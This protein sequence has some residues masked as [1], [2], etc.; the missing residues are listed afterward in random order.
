VYRAASSAKLPAELVPAAAFG[1]AQADLDQ[2]GAGSA[3]SAFAAHFPD[4]PANRGAGVFTDRLLRLAL[5]DSVNYDRDVKPWLG[6][7]VA[8]AGW[9]DDG[10]LQWEAL[11]ATTDASTARSDLTRLLHGQGLV[12]T[13]G[14]A[15]IAA[16]QKAAEDAV[17]AARVKSL[18]TSSLYQHDISALPGSDVA[19]A[20]FDGAEA[21]PALP[22]PARMMLSMVPAAAELLSTH[23]ALGLRFS[24]TSAELD[25]RGVDTKAPGAVSTS[26]LTG[27]PDGTVG[28]IEL[29]QPDRIL[30]AMGG[31]LALLPLEAFGQTTVSGLA[32]YGHITINS[33]PGASSTCTETV[34]GVTQPCGTV[35]PAHP[36]PPPPS[37]FRLI[38]RF[39]GLRFPADFAALL[40]DRS[41]IAFGGIGL[42]GPKVAVRSHPADLA[43]ALTLA[44]RLAGALTHH[45]GLGLS[46]TTTGGDLVIATGSGYARQ[47]VSGGSLG[48]QPGFR[49]AMGTLPAAVNDAG[50]LD[51]ARIAA[52]L[53]GPA[54]AVLDHLKFLGFWGT[55]DGSALTG[56]FRLVVG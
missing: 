15:V 31:A 50:Y 54:P 27:L 32:T 47:I 1:F 7:R 6:S 30:S 53:H 16:T 19:R 36:V 51:F 23:F 48:S 4:F 29:S 2:I 24:S 46:V 35:L 38:Q 37:P 55:V 49:E 13:D 8:V 28:A 43:H 40:G 26:T 11:L 12:L 10:K 52:L 5:K 41:V 42:S 14:Y 45:T 44:N 18:S 3:A 21:A 33:A 20:W 56:Q 25:V 39:T 34:N 17:A 9:V 22:T